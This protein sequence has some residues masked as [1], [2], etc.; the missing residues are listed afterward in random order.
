LSQDSYKGSAYA[1]WTQHLYTYTGNNPVNFIDPT[2]HKGEWLAV[3]GVVAAAVAITA[4]V[5]VSGGA[6]VP[7]V[8]AAA[9]AFGTSYATAAAV[10]VVAAGTVAVS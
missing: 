2:G 6:A 10:T 4:I 3:F 7:L 5:V 1:P 8:A 9:T